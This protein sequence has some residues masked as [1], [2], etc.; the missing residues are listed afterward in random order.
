[1][2]TWRLSYKSNIGRINSITF[3]AQPVHAGGL[4]SRPDL[5]RQR[6]RAS[7]RPFRHSDNTSA[8]RTGPSRLR[9]WTRLDSVIL[10]S[11]R[12]HRILRPAV[13]P[14][15]DRLLLVR[16]AGLHQCRLTRAGVAVGTAGHDQRDRTR[17][18][19]GR[20]A[21]WLFD[22]WGPHGCSCDPTV[23]AFRET[24]PEIIRRGNE[25]AGSVSN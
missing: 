8:H 11:L 12:I 2:P 25:I 1:M 4:Q 23:L 6:R 19:D 21:E 15:L 3:A 9:M 22:P 5:S 18:P 20:P 24:A 14:Q 17:K 13:I 7:L 16:H 10:A